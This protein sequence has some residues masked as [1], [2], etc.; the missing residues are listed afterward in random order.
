MN[1]KEFE[2]KSKT[3]TGWLA[4]NGAEVLQP[5][6][7]WEI[8]RYRDGAG[9]AIAYKNAR[10]FLTMTGSMSEAFAAF[11]GGKPWRAC[12]AT[13]RKNYGSVISRTL[14]QRDGDRCF[15]CCM[16]VEPEDES[17]EH[18][19]ATTHGGPNH[20]SNFFLAHRRCNADAGHLSAPEKI[21]IHVSAKLAG[22]AVA[23]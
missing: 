23:S 22:Q 12:L 11:T 13:K 1:A 2:K 10:G 9:T 3:F 19:V 7:E 5:T 18:L 16:K 6:N 15:F 14:R 17:V 8:V 20:L 21:A 4:A